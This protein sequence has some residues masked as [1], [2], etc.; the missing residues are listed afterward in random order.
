VVLSND[1]ANEHAPAVTVIP[2]V[3]WT[4]ERATRF[5]MVDLRRPRSTLSEH[6]LAN[7]SMITSYD[8][9]RVV[10]YAGTVSPPA[11]TAIEQAVRRHLGL[12]ADAL[13][14]REREVEYELRT[15]P[16]RT[17]ERK[18]LRRRSRR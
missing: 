2:T 17:G 18:P 9:D 4:E 1:R 12:L 10:E 15:T 5:Y 13:E 3:E 7:C 6:R 14:L 16:T 11:I 8:R